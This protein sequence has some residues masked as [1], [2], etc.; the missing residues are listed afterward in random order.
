M[1]STKKNNSDSSSHKLSVLIHQDGLSF[2]VYNDSDIE[3]SWN[4]NFSFQANPIEI[5][6]ELKE[7]FNSEN[8][9]L[10]VPFKK[11]TIIYHHPIFAGVPASVYND[12]HAASYLKY[13]CKLLGTDVISADDPIA[14]I[15]YQT[16]YIAY[17][18]INN[19]FFDKYGDFEYYHYSSLALKAWSSQT[20]DVKK[21]CIVDIKDSYFYL[22]IWESNG[23]LLLHNA[24]PYQTKEDIL[25][26]LLFSTQKNEVN[27]NEDAYFLIDLE[28]NKELF[29]LLF[30]YIRHIEYVPQQQ[31]VT[32]DILCV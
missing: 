17:S 18:N 26:Y 25:Y 6:E 3:T 20:D 5:L 21:T 8:T 12:E 24:F 13:N 32:Q 4:R 29:N 16:V 14:S 10:D 7:E 22:S 27:P 19:Y 28:E 1:Q 30:T 11:V 2:Y 9:W 15:D 31:Q 23:Q